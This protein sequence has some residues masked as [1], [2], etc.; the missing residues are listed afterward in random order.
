MSTGKHTI[1]PKLDP[2]TERIPKKS[3]LNPYEVYKQKQIDIEK[4][5]KANL[6]NNDISNISEPNSSTTETNIGTIPNPEDDRPNSK[7]E[8]STNPNQL[9]SPAVFITPN[10]EALD[11]TRPDP[12]VDKPNPNH[13]SIPN[14]NQHFTSLDH[15][16]YTTPNPEKALDSTRPDPEVD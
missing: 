12:E 11:S 6:S 7:L 16:N 1:E 5:V 2:I 3:K 14:P 10:K 4:S 9:S 13:N 8:T 15:N